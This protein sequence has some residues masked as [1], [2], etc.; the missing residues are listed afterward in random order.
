MRNALCVLCYKLHMFLPCQVYYYMTDEKLLN[1]N[2][3]VGWCRD[4]KFVALLSLVVMIVHFWQGNFD[5]F[6]E[7]PDNF[8]LHSHTFEG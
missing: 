3:A 4:F 8:L 5:G 7:T 2:L 1:F 6:I